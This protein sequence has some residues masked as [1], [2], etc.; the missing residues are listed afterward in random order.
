VGVLG[1]ASEAAHD[2][3]GYAYL[4]ELA[5]SAKIPYAEFHRIND[6][7]VLETVRGWQPDILFVVGLSQLVK[8]DLL[9]I[10]KLGCV[11]FHPTALPRG[12][13]RAPVAWLV[14]DGCPGAATFFAMDEGTDSGPVFVQEPISISC[15]DSAQEVIARVEKAIDIALDRWLP[16][17]L[18]GEW[19]PQQQEEV[20]ATYY[21]RRAPADGLIDWSLSAEEIHALI[22][23]ASHPHPGAYTYYDN[24]KLIVWRSTLTPKLP[25]RGVIG[26][27]VHSDQDYGWLVQTGQGLLW[28]A[29]VVLAENENAS[30]SFELRVGQRLGYVHDDEIFTLKKR[31]SWLEKTLSDLQAVVSPQVKI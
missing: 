31:L 27:I 11:G 30:R 3:S 14:L 23:A 17:L 1:L 25:Y 26:R 12:R 5:K 15:N 24:I 19:K 21:G 8:N 16:R 18:A 9:A 13:G 6:S 2:V 22:R 20:L 4:G 7:L 29:E 10:P 28:L